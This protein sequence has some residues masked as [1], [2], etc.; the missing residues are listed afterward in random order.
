MSDTD[1]TMVDFVE[2]W[3]TGALVLFGSVF[4]GLVLG[5]VLGSWLSAAAGM[6]GFVAG[7]VLAFLAFSYV[8]YGR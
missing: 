3:Q 2:E 6:A 8:R 1:K 4:S 7:T 5:A